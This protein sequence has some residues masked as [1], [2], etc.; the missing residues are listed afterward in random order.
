MTLC[1]IDVDRFKQV[2]DR[3][4]HPAGDA[5]L[6]ILGGLIEELAPGDGYRLGGDELALLVKDRPAAA[7]HIMTELQRRLAESLFAAVSENV[8]VSGGLASFPEHAGDAATLK[9]RADLALYRS[10]HNGKNRSSL[11]EGE[12]EDDESLKPALADIRLHAPERFV[13]VVDS[14]DTYI[15]KHSAAVGILVEAIGRTLGLDEREV[16]QLRIAGL[17]HDLGKIG[18]PDSV[19]NKPG[20]LD[21]DEAELMRKHPQIAFDILDGNDLAPVDTWILHHHERWD[22]E[23]YPFGLAGARIPFGSRIIL[24][25]DAFEAM[26]TDRSYRPAISTEAAMEE[27]RE[28]AGTQF[29]PLVVSALERYLA[30]QGRHEPALETVEPVWSS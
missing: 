15:G 28:H 3:H 20:T 23:G 21:V 7:G 24:V 29:D 8:T 13:A 6:K 9:K 17:L 1:L 11:Y 14:R 16:E 2:N 10:K 26:T 4:G 22:G 19:L 27:L 30:E 12:A 25:A 5:I 18:L